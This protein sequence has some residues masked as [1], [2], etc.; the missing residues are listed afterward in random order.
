M[1]AYLLGYEDTEV[2]P[3]GPGDSENDPLSYPNMFCLPRSN[4]AK[5]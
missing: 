2:T 1:S 4:T 3:E 5:Y